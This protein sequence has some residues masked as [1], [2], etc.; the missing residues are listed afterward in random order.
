[1]TDGPLPAENKLVAD[2]PMY[3]CTMCHLNPSPWWVTIDVDG[4]I[5]HAGFDLKPCGPIMGLPATPKGTS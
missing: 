4:I 5:Y 1:M 3:V 2:P